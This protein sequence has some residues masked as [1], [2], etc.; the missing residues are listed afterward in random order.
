MSS[1]PLHAS[2]GKVRPRRR[3]HSLAFL[4]FMRLFALLVVADAS[5]VVHHLLFRTAR[6]P[7]AAEGLLQAGACLLLAYFLWFR[8]RALFVTAL[9]LEIRLGSSVRI[10]PWDD[11]IDL[12]EVRWMTLQPRWHPRWFQ[13]DLAG[14]EA[15]EF[16]GRRDARQIV[17]ASRPSP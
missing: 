3:L 5:R 10:I 16:V 14:G 1:E 7:S 4:W 13:I 2:G 17:I 11:V 6:T 8:A 9:G 12:R 15:L